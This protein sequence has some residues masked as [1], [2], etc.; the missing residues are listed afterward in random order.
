[1][2]P[3]AKAGSF[4]RVR[5]FSAD[6]S[7]LDRNRFAAAIR[8]PSNASNDC[9]KLPAAHGMYRLPYGQ[10]NLHWYSYHDNLHV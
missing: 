3:S 1:M 4:V 2:A 9:M 7:L 10:L 5:V 8:A 6:S